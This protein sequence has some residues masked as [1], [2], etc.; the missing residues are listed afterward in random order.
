MTNKI[1]DKLVDISIYCG[2]IE[3]EI[4]EFVFEYEEDHTAITIAKESSKAYDRLQETRQ[5]LKAQIEI[6]KEL[7]KNDR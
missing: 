5:K 7:L 1:I 3:H 6:L 2:R 4:D